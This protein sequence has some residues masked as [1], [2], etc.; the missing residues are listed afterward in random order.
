LRFTL[1][2]IGSHQK[3]IMYCL[4]HASIISSLGDGNCATCNNKRERFC[5]S[6]LQKTV[7]VFSLFLS[8]TLTC[9]FLL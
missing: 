1:D 7:N 5:V 9:I 3:K 2:H 8:I 4:L 6:R